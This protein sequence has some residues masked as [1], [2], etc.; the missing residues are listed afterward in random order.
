M[1]L[2]LFPLSV[3]PPSFRQN[4]YTW[5]L[6][7]S[8]QVIDVKY[9]S[10]RVNVLTELSVSLAVVIDTLNIA[11]INIKQGKTINLEILKN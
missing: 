8:S 4:T 2:W 5:T 10:T 9:R 6:Q 11:E 1:I 7:Q 3:S